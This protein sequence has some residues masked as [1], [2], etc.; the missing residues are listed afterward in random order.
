MTYRLKEIT[1]RTNNSE[2]G[3]SKIVE[4]WEDVQSGKLPLLIDNNGGFLDKV[5]PVSKYSN[6]E[7]DENGDYD[8]SIMAVGREFFQEMDK[9][10]EK[11][12]YV[13]FDGSDDDGDLTKSTKRAWEMVWKA[14]TSGEINRAFSVDYE[15]SVPAQYTKDGKAHSYL[16]IAVNRR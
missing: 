12:T 2:E 1:I 11:G 13:K 8:F 7:T 10:V 16:Y 14:Q 3:I 4:I 6:Y 15:S 9:E 5:S